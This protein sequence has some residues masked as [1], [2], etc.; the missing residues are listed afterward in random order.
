M[1]W[2]LRDPWSDKA[3]CCV[4]CFDTDG[5]AHGDWEVSSY[6][7]RPCTSRWPYKI[8]NA[9]YGPPPSFRQPANAAVDPAAS[10]HLA[11]LMEDAADSDGE[12][13]DEGHQ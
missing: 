5:E 8:L 6:S 7:P 13:E 3:Y 4:K 12:D 2:A 1:G 11:A 9:L 10:T